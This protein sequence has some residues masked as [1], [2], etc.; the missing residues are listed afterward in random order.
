MKPK[1]KLLERNALISPAL[2]QGSTSGEDPDLPMTFY[3]RNLSSTGRSSGGCRLK[4]HRQRTA[5]RGGRTSHE[6]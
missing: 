3:G 4:T 2:V 6:D 5:R 1:S